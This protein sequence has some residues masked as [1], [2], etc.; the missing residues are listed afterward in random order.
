VTW[1]DASNTQTTMGVGVYSY[2]SD[3]VPSDNY[4]EVAINRS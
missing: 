2:I 1:I 4:V 3:P